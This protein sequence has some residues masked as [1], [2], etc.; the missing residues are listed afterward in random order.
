MKYRGLQKG[1]PRGKSLNREQGGFWHKLYKLTKPL[2]VRKSTLVNFLSHILT[3]CTRNLLVRDLRIFSPAANL[4]A[5]P[6]I[7]N[8]FNM[9]A[10]S[11][12]TE[13]NPKTTAVQI[14]N[15]A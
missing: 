12:F 1:W 13:Q 2:N 3:I 14:N 11:D 6:C 15:G 9:I 10:T 5:I 4:S 8:V 7:P